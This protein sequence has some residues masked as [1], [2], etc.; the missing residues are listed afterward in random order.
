VYDIRG[1][2]REFPAYRLEDATV[3]GMTE[4]IVSSLLLHLRD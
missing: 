2:P 1:E 3:W 4:R